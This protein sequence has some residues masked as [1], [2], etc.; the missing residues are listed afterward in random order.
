MLPIHA[1]D[2]LLFLPAVL[3]VA[4]MQAAIT[5]KNSIV[6]YLFGGC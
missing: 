4:H 5:A 6:Y 2:I 3:F 1:S